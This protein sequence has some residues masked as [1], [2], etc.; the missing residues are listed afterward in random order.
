MCGGNE[1]P[2]W[3]KTWAHNNQNKEH[4]NYM[5]ESFSELSIAFERV[6]T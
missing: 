5:V 6:V 3:Q 4:I 2:L 1:E